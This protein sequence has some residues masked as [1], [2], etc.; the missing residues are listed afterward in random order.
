MSGL[1]VTT[2]V[3]YFYRIINNT[4]LQTRCELYR[5]EVLGVRN[6]VVQSEII[7]VESKIDIDTKMSIVCIVKHHRQRDR[8]NDIFTVADTE[9]RIIGVDYFGK[10]FVTGSWTRKGVQ[11]TSFGRDVVR[12]EIE[13]EDGRDRSTQRVSSGDDSRLVC[14][15]VLYDGKQSFTHAFI[16]FPIGGMYENIGIILRDKI[17]IGRSKIRVRQPGIKRGTSRERDNHDVPF[18]AVVDNTVLSVLIAVQIQHFDR[19]D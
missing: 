18:A 1:F 6:I 3:Y 5:I 7:Q 13:K 19:A 12:N 2:H 16:H 10:P 17:R 11:H 15:H 9:R 14:H 4:F 8:W